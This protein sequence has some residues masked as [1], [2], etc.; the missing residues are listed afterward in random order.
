[1]EFLIMRYF[2]LVTYTAKVITRETQIW[3]H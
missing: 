3:S 1:M 2:K